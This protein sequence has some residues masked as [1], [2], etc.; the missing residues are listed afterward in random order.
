MKTERVDGLDQLLTTASE[1]VDRQRQ[2]NDAIA[3]AKA[4]TADAT[5]TKGLSQLNLELALSNEALQKPTAEQ[6]V[7]EAEQASFEAR[8]ELERAELTLAGLRNQLTDKETNLALADAETK[9]SAAIPGLAQH[10]TSD[11]R[12]KY[13]AAYTVFLGVLSQGVALD[14]SL[15][16]MPGVRSQL[17]RDVINAAAPTQ[18]PGTPLRQN[19]EQPTLEIIVP[20]MDEVTAMMKLDDAQLKQTLST[21]NE[22]S[23]ARGLA[24][25]EAHRVQREEYRRD[26]VAGNGI[27]KIARHPWPA[28]KIAK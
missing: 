12:L 23:W 14:R 25:G 8:E 1:L 3:A 9:L 26:R 5:L 7:A 17:V 10:A 11:W 27:S 21:K 4:K 28:E 6:E 16:T 22:V 19:P 2:I 24:I 18:F 20:R 13:D 15:H